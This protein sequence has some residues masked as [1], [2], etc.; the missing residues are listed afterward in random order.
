MALFSLVGV[1]L[2]VEDIEYIATNELITE[3]N[4]AAGLALVN[5][6]AASKTVEQLEDLAANG[7]TVGLRLA[8]SEALKKVTGSVSALAS[9]TVDELLALGQEG[10]A[11]A[12]F[13]HALRAFSGFDEEG[14]EAFASDDANSEALQRG[15]GE[16]L[17][18]LWTPG[19]MR[20]K[21]V[22]ELL[23]IVDNGA[24]AGI[25]Y[26]AGVAL[27]IYWIATKPLG[28][29]EVEVEILNTLNTD[30]AEAYQGYLAYLYESEL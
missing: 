19:G 27:K 13:V 30:L 29:V 7:R 24:T 17:G 28:I 9:L 6:Y 26:A 15:A 25:R 3:I 16:F 5:E 4:N 2:T 18:A 14:L 8:G 1:G 20:E 12:G 10:D 21:S 23:D 11:D 22:A